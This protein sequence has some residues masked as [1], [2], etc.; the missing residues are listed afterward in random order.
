MKKL[1]KKHKK[2][3]NAVREYFY[4]F[5]FLPLIWGL[6]LPTIIAISIKTNFSFLFLDFVLVMQ[7]IFILYAVYE[8]KTSGY[9]LIHIY[10]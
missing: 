4:I 8:I 7:I 5:G 6:S 9:S 10:K 1:K 2:T 3:D